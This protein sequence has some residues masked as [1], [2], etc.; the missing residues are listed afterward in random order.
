[1]AWTS[2]ASQAQEPPADVSAPSG[3]EQ[4]VCVSP[5]TQRLISIY[6]ADEGRNAAC[7]VDYTRDGKTQ[8][9][10]TASHD[11][12]Y[13]VRKALSLVRTLSKD[14]FKCKP[15]SEPTPPQSPARR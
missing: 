7:R 9:L 6:R 14:N 15:E 12:A 10:W 2:V 11:Y 13:C 8:T 4:F 3:H 1:M 5:S